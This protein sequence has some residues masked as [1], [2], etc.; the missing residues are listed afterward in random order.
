MVP[1]APVLGLVQTQICARTRGCGYGWAPPVMLAMAR[2][3][4][5]AQEVQANRATQGVWHLNG[6]ATPMR[7]SVWQ[8][9]RTRCWS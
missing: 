4:A 7:G 2:S 8:R 6:I 1:D 3:P 5:V 9:A